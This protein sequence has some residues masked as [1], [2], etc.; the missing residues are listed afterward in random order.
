MLTA[1]DNMTGAGL[2]LAIAANVAQANGGTIEVRTSPDGST[3]T[4]TFPPDPRA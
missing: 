2:G 3:F 1:R 4:L